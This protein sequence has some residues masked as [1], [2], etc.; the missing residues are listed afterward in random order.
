MARMHSISAALASAAY[1]V[2]AAPALVLA[3]SSPPPTG[4]P[5]TPQR[6]SPA[7]GEGGGAGWLWL[8]LAVA[9]IAIVWYAMAARRRTA[10]RTR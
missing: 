7:T 3:Q 8:L 10:T 1:A 2:L 6:G 9:V 4:G 5:I